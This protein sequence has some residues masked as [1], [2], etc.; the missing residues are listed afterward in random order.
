[1]SEACEGAI[2]ALACEA[3]DITAISCGAPDLTPINCGATGAVGTIECCYE[4]PPAQQ[5][6]DEP[7]VPEPYGADAGPAE[8]PGE[9]SAGFAP[10][11]DVVEDLLP[12]G[13]DFE[14]GQ[15]PGPEESGGTFLIRPEPDSNTAPFRQ[16]H[17]SGDGDVI[18]VPF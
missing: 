5:P 9:P 17:A 14:F 8:A 11:F 12:A 1:M 2:S 6:D 15:I 10:P 13:P 3:A 4:P 18:V 7:R 16:G